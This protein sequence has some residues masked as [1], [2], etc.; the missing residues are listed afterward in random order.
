MMFLVVAAILAMVVAIDTGRTRYWVL[1]AVSCA[2]AFYT[3]YTSAFVLGVALLWLLWSEPE[4]RRPA[5]LATAGAAVLVAPWIPGLIADLQSPTLKILS[6]LSPFTA[7][8]VRIDIQHWAL[9]YPYAIAGTGLKDLPGGPA[10]VLLAIAAVLT[11]AGLWLRARGGEGRIAQLLRRQRALSSDE[12]RLLLVFAL[13]L[14]TPVCEIL[15]SAFGNHI[16]GVRDLAASWPFLALSAGATIV[17]AGSRLGAVAAILAVIAFAF[18]AAKMLDPGFRRPDYQA[19]ANFVAAAARPGDVVVDDTGGLSPGPLTAFD[20]T[21]HGSLPV[22]RAR[23]PA[24]RDHPFT[25]FDPFVSL[26]TAVARAVSATPGGR[27][28][29]VAPE[30]LTTAARPDPAGAAF[31]P[32]YRMVAER[33]YEG[34]QPTLVAVYARAP[35]S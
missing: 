2:A 8:A 16:I 20:V 32:G 19:A 26:N 27:V 4:A 13:M 18:G 6:A 21:Y 31:P 34:I 25:V 29:V 1:F 5:L 24:E 15:A 10:L 33:K 28:F 7:G 9:G 11:V 14:A 35:A 22:F 30:L 23:S 12:R 3:H 17:A